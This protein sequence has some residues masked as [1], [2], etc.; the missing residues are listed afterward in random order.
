MMRNPKSLLAAIELDFPD[1]TF[2]LGRKA[3][4]EVAP[5]VRPINSARFRRNLDVIARRLRRRAASAVGMLIAWYAV[6]ILAAILSMSPYANVVAIGTTAG[7]SVWCINVM[8][9]MNRELFATELLIAAVQ[10]D[11]AYLGELIAYCRAILAG[12][13]AVQAL[14]AAPAP[15]KRR[16][17]AA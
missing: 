17:A 5:E 10:E 4:P 1:D 13:L 15:A 6:V 7:G 2:V 14:P 8:R 3:T 9:R 11:S 12:A 16:A